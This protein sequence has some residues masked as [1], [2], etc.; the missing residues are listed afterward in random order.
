MM[1]SFFGYLF[2]N[3]IDFF[4]LTLIIFSLFFYYMIINKSIIINESK[5]IIIVAFFLLIILFISNIYYTEYKITEIKSL[6]FR[7]LVII[8]G[9]LM[10]F[11]NNWQN[12][13]IKIFYFGSLV[14]V[15]FTVFSFLFT[16]IFINYILILFPK[17]I[18]NT[19][20]MFSHLGAYSGI[21]NQ[22]G[23]NGYLISVAIMISF[24]YYITNNKKKLN[25]I[26]FFLSFFALFL[27]SKRGHIFASFISIVF[28][29]IVYF[30]IKQKKV[31][32]KLIILLIV[33]MLFV[34]LLCFLI[35]DVYN[36]LLRFI[37]GK[38][39]YTSG[40]LYLYNNA[41]KMILEKPIFGWGGN[42]FGNLYDMSVHNSYLQIFVENGIFAVLLLILIL[43]IN[44]IYTINFLFIK[45][46]KNIH[47][48]DVM[49]LFSLYYQFF[50]IIHNLIS[51]P[52]YYHF[53]L[54]VY[55]LAIAIPFSLNDN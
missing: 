46:K 31:I 9:L 45:T 16:D 37:P 14:H 11:E 40:R 7:L 13:L 34:T 32:F 21:T 54:I 27:T 3:Y 48:N 20:N 2:N 41:I 24:I 8:I 25:L 52:F 51:S 18:M 4:I 38:G 15:L 53:V 30:R 50:F 23:T 22:T 10:F 12:I 6:V 35:P 33:F 26:L 39:S 29:T 36:I 17:E 44:L 5:L 49:L 1:F 47:K 55:M 19:F 43:L 42:T 28:I